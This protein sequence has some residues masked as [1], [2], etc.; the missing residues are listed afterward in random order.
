MALWMVRAGSTGENE[1]LALQKNRVVISFHEIGDLSDATDRDSIKQEIMSSMPDTQEGRLNN[2]AGQLHA[3]VNRIKQ[4]DLVAM[5]L[6]SQPAIAFGRIVGP[7]E[8]RPDFPQSARHARPVEWEREDVPRSA[9]DQD[10]LYSFGAFL[11]VCQIKRNNAEERVLAVL[12]GR[13]PAVSIPSES[14]DETTD[15][16][17]AY[18]NI[19][20]NSRDMIAQRVSER[21]SGHEFERLLDEIL[22]AEGYS[23][24]RTAPGPDRGVD[25]MAGSGKLGFDAPRLAVQAKSGTTPQGSPAI[26][27]LRGAMD[28][29]G[30]QQGLFVSWGGYTQDALRMRRQLFF[31]VRMWDADDVLDAIFRNYEQ[32]PE[33]IKVELPLRRI[34]TLY[35]EDEG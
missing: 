18:F 15:V 9:F 22:K 12:E 19:E 7:Y 16:S 26:T 29:F 1:D 21:F 25:I 33:D 31:R 34:W 27:Q 20:Q 13:S 2:W 10:I 11:T 3:F 17:A 28:N 30:A 24:E 35:L 14:E 5:P 23:T 32:L 8:Y 6:K 4:G